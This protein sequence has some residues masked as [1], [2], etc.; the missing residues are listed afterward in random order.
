LF[1]RIASAK[2]K[3]VMQTI[4]DLTAKKNST[5]TLDILTSVEKRV[6]KSV[7]PHRIIR[8]LNNLEE[9]GLI[10]KSLVSVGKA[11]LLTWKQAMLRN[12]KKSADSNLSESD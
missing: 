9:Y 4:V 2:E 5:T 7:N 11:P 6:R 12:I 10:R 1:R 8:I 3:I